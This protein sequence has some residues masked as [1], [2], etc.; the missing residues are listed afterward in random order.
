MWQSTTTEMRISSFIVCYCATD[1]WMKIGIRHILVPLCEVVIC[2][3]YH[4]NVFLYLQRLANKLVLSPEMFELHWVEATTDFLSPWL[5]LELFVHTPVCM[6][7]SRF[8]QQFLKITSDITIPIVDKIETCLKMFV[9]SK[10]SIIAS[11]VEEN[12]LV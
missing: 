2:I 10:I 6:S 1:E 3:N 11:T 7:S 9:V 4:F 5:F 12:V 8:V